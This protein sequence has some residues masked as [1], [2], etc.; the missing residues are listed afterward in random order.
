MAT[1]CTTTATAT[2][3]SLITTSSVTTTF[4]ESVTTESATVTTIT[5]AEC[6]PLG[7]L[8]SLSSVLCLSTI[9]TITSTVSGGTSTIQVPVTQTI[10]VTDTTTLTL[11]GSSCTVFSSTSGPASSSIFTPPPVPPPS[12]SANS[13]PIGPSSQPSQTPTS[14]QPTSA[15]DVNPT[16][17]APSSDHSSTAQTQTNTDG[18]SSSHIGPIVGGV[19]AGF[20]GL[21]GIALIIWFI[22]KRRRR[23]DDIFDQEYSSR[24]SRTTKR[25][26]LDTDIEPKPYQYGLVGQT[27]S[28]SI[29]ISPP[30]S[31]PRTLQQLPPHNLTPLT[32]PTS[33]STPGLSATTMSSRPSTAGSM[34]PLDPPP[35]SGSRP[36][37]P[38]SL[39]SLTHNHSTS[40]ESSTGVLSLPS[41]WGHHS[42]SP[43]ADQ[44]HMEP[45]RSGSPTSVHEYNY[46]LQRRLQ[47]AN[48]GDDEVVPSPPTPTPLAGAGSGTRAGAGPALL[49]G[50]GRHVRLGS[51]G[52]GVLVHTDGGPAPPD[53]LS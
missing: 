33:A 47:L 32:L 31:P 50:K 18:S 35:G 5:T 23:W 13:L 16:T 30:N 26:S 36:P 3:T 7:S 41:N 21:L 37:P 17:S 38:T 2:T 10:P 52:P 28:P 45:L 24:P 53:L 6:P 22:M 14:T 34:R 43:S 4:T 15:P 44:A 46:M 8:G 29:G 48:V 1:S 12:Q 9:S 11:F 39:P 42:P 20:F 51:G 19:L 27:K 49:D 40:S 25:F